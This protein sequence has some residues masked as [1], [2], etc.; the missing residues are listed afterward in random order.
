[1]KILFQTSE[2]S[3]ENNSWCV[4]S[5][6][7]PNGHVEA[8]VLQY[9]AELQR[10]GF[11]VVLVSTS[12]ELDDASIIALKRVATAAILRENTGYDF[13]SYKAGIT[14]LT[15]Q[16]IKPERLLVTNDS[17]FGPFHDL[18]QVF[19][20]AQEYDLYGLTD[21]FDFHHH[22]Q[23]YFLLY[24]QRVLQGPDFTEFWDGVELIDSGQPGF[25]QKI[26]MQYEVGGTQHFLGRGYSIGAAY[27]FSEILPR[28]VEAY[29]A[30]LREAK[31][32]VGSSVRPLDIKFNTTHRFWDTLLGMGYPFLKRELLLLNPTGADITNWSD[33]KSVV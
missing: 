16:G 15:N 17:V 26:I 21:S 27:P 8:Y 24:G 1:M 6:F 14:Y 10:C 31:L 30:Q 33:R 9:L 25:K 22:L 12:A 32:E 7:D 2:Y 11:S 20:A 19:K 4:F 28:A 23:S 13:G 3:Q 18:D 5:H 29:L